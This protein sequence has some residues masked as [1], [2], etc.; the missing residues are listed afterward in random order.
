M[1]T[2]LIGIDV[3]APFLKLFY[4]LSELFVWRNRGEDMS[5]HHSDAFVQ[6]A[7]NARKRIREITP[8][9]LAK[10]KQ[11]PLIVDVREK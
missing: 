7:N 9:E 11:L 4:D 3:T 10:F 8:A 6:L 5:V 1:N 2:S